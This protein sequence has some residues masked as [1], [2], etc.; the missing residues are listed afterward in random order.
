MRL[1]IIK[2]SSFGDVLHAF[3]PVALIRSALPPEIRISWVVNEAFVDVVGL[4]PG[5]D[6]VVPFPRQK[7]CSLSCIR[8]FLHA[9]RA[10]E[11]DLAIDYQGLLRSGLIAK[12]SRAREK[13]GFAHAREGAPLFY[14]RKLTIPNLQSHA[15]DKN[16][17]LTR[18][19]LGIDASH[20]QPP[21]Q[22]QIPADG[23]EEAARLLPPGDA[24]LLA[25]CF[26]SRWESKNWSPRFIAETLDSL[27][28]DIP[29]VQPILVGA[30][31]DWP[32]GEEILQA[33]R[34]A[35]PLNLAGKSSF[36]GL[37]AILSR[38][39]AMFTVDS[40]PMHLAAALGVPCIAMFGST[41]P[42][43]TGPYGPKGF[44]AILSS[45]C[46]SAPCM[47]RECPLHQNCAEGFS[48][49]AA[50]DAIAAKLQRRPS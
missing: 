16:L 14:T 37:A 10:E 46:A 48:A 20:L 40:G 21:P 27:A 31:A 47:K 17:E 39:S 23:L 15:V 24:P 35:R 9:L 32:L 8:E 30:T 42:T 43:L 13:V 3:P 6:R 12:A 33:A 5:V 38:A 44:H 45:R 36:H 19:A 22:F 7:L 50:A 18:F 26:S 41:S 11:Y 29:G 1:L 4:C 25:V 2:P 28:R 34:M 49:Q